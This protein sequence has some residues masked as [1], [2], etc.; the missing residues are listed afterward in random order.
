MEVST[1]TPKGVPVHRRYT[2]S[3]QAG[4]RS[5]QGKTSVQGVEFSMGCPCAHTIG[6]AP[7]SDLQQRRRSLLDWKSP[8]GGVARVAGA[9]RQWKRAGSTQRNGGYRAIPRQGN[10][11]MGVCDHAR[12]SNSSCNAG[13]AH[14]EA[15]L[16]GSYVSRSV[17]VGRMRALWCG[18]EGGT[19]MQDRPS[20]D[21]TD[22]SFTPSERDHA[23]AM[24]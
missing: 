24:P 19:G 6:Q 15:E 3:E 8:Q 13:A 16:E 14:G 11:L 10:K 18:A 7:P 4:K 21:R 20:G 2:G 1:R 9:V 17:G 22:C 23:V 12:E 5:A